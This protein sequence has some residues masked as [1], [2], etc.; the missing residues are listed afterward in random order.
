ML[1]TCTTE[2]RA[3][4]LDKT[5]RAVQAPMDQRD[6][7]TTTDLGYAGTH[8]PLLKHGNIFAASTKTFASNRDGLNLCTHSN[9][10]R[11]RHN[12]KI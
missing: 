4:N 9:I 5:E 10:P 7:N 12:I 8:I 6:T 11:K 1:V 2:A 3:Q